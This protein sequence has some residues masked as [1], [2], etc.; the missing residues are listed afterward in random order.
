MLFVD[1][2]YN[3]SIH[4]SQCIMGALN[5]GLDLY[6]TYLVSHFGGFTGLSTGQRTTVRSVKYRAPIVPFW[7]GF[8]LW[9]CQLFLK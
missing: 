2:V 4:R 1:L 8:D 9:R 5:S 6:Q 7:L 3:Y